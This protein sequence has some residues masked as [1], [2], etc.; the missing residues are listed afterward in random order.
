[1]QHTIVEINKNFLANKNMFKVSN[2]NTRK[3]TKALLKV[4]SFSGI[5]AVNV[6]LG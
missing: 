5:F 3:R 2:K 1:M 4:K 6:K